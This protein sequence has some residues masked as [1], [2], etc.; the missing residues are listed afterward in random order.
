[1]INITVP[2]NKEISLYDIISDYFMTGQAL[3]A[4]PI[5]HSFSLLISEGEENKIVVKDIHYQTLSSILP[6]VFF[7]DPP[8]YRSSFG[9]EIFL[10]NFD[11]VEVKSYGKLGLTKKINI[12]N[13]KFPYEVHIELIVSKNS[14]DSVKCLRINFVGIGDFMIP[15]KQNKDL[16]RHLQGTKMK[17]IRIHDLPNDD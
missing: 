3:V 8:I 11:F 2:N 6:I 17:F 12:S 7:F 15:F 4:E 5:K 14:I 13:V 16:I 1:M 10:P 9:R